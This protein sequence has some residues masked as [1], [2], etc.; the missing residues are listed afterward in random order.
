LKSTT[1]EQE[2]WQG[3]RNEAGVERAGAAMRK[4]GLKSFKGRT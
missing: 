1:G 4:N 3:R 2:S